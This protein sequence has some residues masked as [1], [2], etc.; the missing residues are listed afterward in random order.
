MALFDFQAD[1]AEGFFAACRINQFEEKNQ[2]RLL[3]S[4][5]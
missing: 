5:D 2:I 4:L 3:V 1:L